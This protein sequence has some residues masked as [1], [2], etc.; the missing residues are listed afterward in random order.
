[1]PWLLDEDA[2]LRQKLTGLGVY[3]GRQNKD[4]IPVQVFYRFP[5]PEATPRTYP[6]I[7]IDLIDVQFDATRAHR[8]AE[9]VLD[10]VPAGMP[11]PPDTVALVQGD[12]PLPWQL[13]YQISAFSRDP[14]QDRQLQYTMIALFPEQFGFLDMGT[15][16]GT[17]RRADLIGTARND[18][19][20]EE[21]KRVF[22]KIYTVSISSELSLEAVRQ[23]YKTL[24]A[25]SITL[26]DYEGPYVTFPPNITV[27]SE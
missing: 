5:D 11:P 18:R 25:P 26:L 3:A 20:D 13:I 1:M 2:A 19:I 4:L 12:R 23:V 8:A 22:E 21:N 14:L 6:H 7:A 16:D 9:T 10:Y 15:I 24:Q 17:V 27:T